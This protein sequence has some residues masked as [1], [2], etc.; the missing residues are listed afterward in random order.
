MA[1]PGGCVGG[2][3]QPSYRDLNVRKKRAKLLYE[4]DK[5]L[6]LHKPQDNPYVKKVYADFIGDPNGHKAHEYLHVK[7]TERK[8][9]NCKI[10]KEIKG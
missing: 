2:A 8:R 10:I 3:G 1:C 7:H 4:N 6:E 5:S 9:L